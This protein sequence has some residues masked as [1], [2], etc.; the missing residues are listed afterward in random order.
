MT[1]ETYVKTVISTGNR[2]IDD[3][4]GGG[5]PLGS[6]TLRLCLKS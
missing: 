2:E 4:M 6:L 3:K 5:V 1:E